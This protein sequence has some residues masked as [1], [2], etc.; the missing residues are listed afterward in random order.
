MILSDSSMGK[1]GRGKVC[2]Q[3]TKQVPR[4]QERISDLGGHERGIQE[5][6]PSKGPSAILGTSLATLCKRGVPPLPSPRPGS[7][8]G[9]ASSLLAALLRGHLGRGNGGEAAGARAGGHGW[10]AS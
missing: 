7:S 2:I 8:S 10:R 6:Q 4:C 3:H 1:H 9:L 5:R